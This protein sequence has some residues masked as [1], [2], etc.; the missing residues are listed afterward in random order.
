MGAVAVRAVRRDDGITAGYAGLATCGR[1]WLCPVCNSKVMALRAIELGV[2]LMWAEANGYSVLWGSLTMYHHAGM[3]LAWMINVQR[4]SWRRLVNSRTWRDFK[5]VR[6]GYVRAAELTVGQNGWHPH[7][8]PIILVKG[9]REVAQA[10]A[11][12]MVETWREGVEE[13]GGKAGGGRA[14][15]LRVLDPGAWTSE[16]SNY[17]TKGQYSPTRK[18]ALEAV[19][20]QSKTGAGRVAG[21]E[22]HWSLLDGA[23]K[24]LADD[25]LAWWEL[26]E[27]THGH[28]MITWSRGLRA[29]AGLGK[30]ATD[31]EV[32]ARELGDKEDTVCYITAQ[33]W[34]QVR[35]LPALQ[36]G[37]LDTLEK[38]GWDAL[39]ALLDRHGVEWFEDAD[40]GGSVR[41]LVK[42]VDP[43]RDVRHAGPIQYVDPDLLA[44]FLK[45]GE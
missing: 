4:A 43:M 8:H 14:Q 44:G 39:R 31:E 13:A 6:V 40:F 32:A 29:A 33:G 1:I 23:G 9:P 25:A 19:W 17:V 36:A 18:L 7:F 3:S 22:P 21:T 10:L 5:E 41:Q 15:Q 26:E 38:G 24:G 35:E 16:L 30:E 12:W 45:L 37:I 28:R 2:V 27:A 42:R 11:D 34:R 20:S